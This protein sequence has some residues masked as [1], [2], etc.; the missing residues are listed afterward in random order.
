MGKEWKPWQ[1][2]FWGA[3]NQCGSSFSHQVERQSL[4]RK[5]ACS[6]GRKVMANLDHIL[7]SR[8]ITLPSTDHIIQAMGFPVDMCGYENW[9]IKK[10]EHE[11][12]DAFEL[13]C[14][15][16]LWR[17]PWTE[18][19]SDQSIHKKLTLNIHW[20]GWCWSWS[21]SILATCCE[22]QTHWKRS[23]CWERLRAGEKG[24]AEDEMVG[25]HHQLSGHLN[26]LREIAKDREA[27]CAALYGV[28]N[29]WTRLN[30][31]KVTS[32][33]PLVLFLF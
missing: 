13:W 5:Q 25:W 14:W 9:N 16:R 26:K 15:R 4:L 12:I 8:D 24:V 6:I 31:R 11:I 29:S 28:S 10:A 33:L 2:L 7:K 30:N 19:R 20:K 32:L 3:P 17:V 1:I 18:R 21:S 22:E 27:W 23:W